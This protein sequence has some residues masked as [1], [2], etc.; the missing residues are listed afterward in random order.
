MCLAGPRAA[1]WSST[2]CSMCLQSSASPAVPGFAG[3]GPAAATRVTDSIELTSKQRIKLSSLQPWLH[4]HAEQLTT[5]HLDQEK[6]KP[7]KLYLPC[8]KLT[9]LQALRL[10]TLH[11]KLLPASS[12]SSSSKGRNRP[13]LPAL[14]QLE[15]CRCQLD[16]LEGLLQLARSTALTSLQL[17]CLDIADSQGDADDRKLNTGKPLLSANISSHVWY[18]LASTCQLLEWLAC[19]QPVWDSG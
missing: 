9:K 7:T 16:T 10:N 19:T 5:L 15:L 14:Q 8:G 17:H 1:N 12:S 4:Q 3:S 2:S 13:L 18:A 6:Y 11:V